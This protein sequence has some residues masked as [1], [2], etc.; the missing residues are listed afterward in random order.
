MQFFGKEPEN[1]PPIAAIVY[2]SNEHLI[3]QQ[4]NGYLAQLEKRQIKKSAN[5]AIL[6]P[7]SPSPLPKGK[8]NFIKPP[9]KGSTKIL[10]PPDG[11]EEEKEKE[12]EEEKEEGEVEV[13]TRER[14][15]P[16]LLGFKKN[17]WEECQ[18]QGL[19]PEIGKAFFEYWSDIDDHSKMFLWQATNPFSIRN[20]LKT[21]SRI[22]KE[23]Q[24]KNG[25]TFNIE[26]SWKYK[27]SPTKWQ[28]F[29]KLAK[30]DGYK[31]KQIQTTGETSFEKDNKQFIV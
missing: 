24:A 23:K 20:R 17:V 6:S 4:V 2:K 11:I 5:Y 28:E 30:E 22:E 29:K 12:K 16:A 1:L 31:I 9:T 7:R 27:D 25:T 18:E 21:W 8:N 15:H 10:K 3:L 14:A 19:T 26:D 13:L